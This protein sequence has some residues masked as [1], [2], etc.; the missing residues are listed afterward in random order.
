MKKFID[1][2]RG[3]SIRREPQSRLNT[4]ETVKPAEFRS[5][6]DFNNR[7]LRF[8]AES[9]TFSPQIN[10]ATDIYPEEYAETQVRVYNLICR[11]KN[12]SLSLR[13]IAYKLEELFENTDISL[14]KYKVFTDNLISLLELLET[15]GDLYDWAVEIDHVEDEVFRPKPD[16]FMAISEMLLPKGRLETRLNTIQL[17]IRSGLE[18][19]VRE[20][21]IKNDVPGPLVSRELDNAMRKFEREGDMAVETYLQGLESVRPVNFSALLIDSTNLFDIYF[22]EFVRNLRAD[23]SEVSKIRRMRDFYNLVK[24]TKTIFKNEYIDRFN[25][26]LESDVYFVDRGVLIYLYSSMSLYYCLLETIYSLLSD[27]QKRP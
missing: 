1:K 16:V 6:F 24:V 18:N 9:D 11:W 22:N 13:E 12:E 23:D 4:V 5:A 25:N 8:I 2:L 17:N 27:M 21:L 10:A 14:S 15:K 7:L 3:G 19:T 26:Y 20:A